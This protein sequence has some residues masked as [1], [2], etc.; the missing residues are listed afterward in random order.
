MA[1]TAAEGILPVRTTPPHPLTSYA[2]AHPATTVVATG[3]PAE[4]AAVVAETLRINGWMPVGRTGAGSLLFE[5]HETR[6]RSAH[7]K[8]FR[9]KRRNSHRAYLTLDAREHGQDSSL[10]LSLVAG[11]FL[12]IDFHDAVRAVSRRFERSSTLIGVR[13]HRS[14]YDLPVKFAGNP[15]TFARHQREWVTG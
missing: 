8:A 5:A 1:D 10:T 4:C 2:I 6:R 13:A 15:I 3:D 12:P 14:A 7:P 9:P 11:D